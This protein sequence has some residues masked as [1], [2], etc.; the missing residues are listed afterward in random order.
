V[1]SCPDT[2]RRVTA[3]LLAEIES[4]SDAPGLHDGWRGLIDFGE[5]WTE[6]DA[7]LAWPPGSATVPLGEPLVYGCEVTY[8]EPG[9][10]SVR[11]RFNALDSLR[12]AVVAG[13]RF[14][15]RDGE[16]ARAHGRVK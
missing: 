5:R 16:T 13:A 7:D 15:L 1:L 8:P 10:D 3:E 14:T 2:V 6:D 12:P 4:F 11:V 9:S